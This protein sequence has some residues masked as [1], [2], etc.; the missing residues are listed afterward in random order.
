MQ[1]DRSCGNVGS[2]SVSRCFLLLTRVSYCCA[3]IY[4]GLAA[5][6][7]FHTS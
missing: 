3:L 2:L 4:P 7:A 6:L 5:N 1:P